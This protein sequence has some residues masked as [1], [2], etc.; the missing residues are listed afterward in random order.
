MW[1]TFT[2]KGEGTSAGGLHLLYSVEEQC[3]SVASESFR[4]SSNVLDYSHPC[5][6]ELAGNI[7]YTEFIAAT[8]NII[9]IYVRIN[10]LADIIKLYYI[11]ASYLLNH[12]YL[13]ELVWAVM[14]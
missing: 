5:L 14:P 6:T 13:I 8:K 10:E 7:N 11:I 3:I 4:P 9:Y 12:N 2:E 1:L